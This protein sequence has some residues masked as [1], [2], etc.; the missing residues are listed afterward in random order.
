M[1]RTCEPNWDNVATPLTIVVAD[2]MY[3]LTPRALAAQLRFCTGR[4]FRGAC[5]LEVTGRRGRRR[6]DVREALAISSY[7]FASSPRE[8]RAKKER[9]AWASRCFSWSTSVA[10]WATC[11]VEGGDAVSLEEPK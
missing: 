7:V 11:L 4:E 1:S 8:R 3:I 9:W 2:Y 5:V 10:S 6:E